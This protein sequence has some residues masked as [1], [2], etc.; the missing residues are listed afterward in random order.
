MHSVR[1]DPH[2]L[3]CLRYKSYPPRIKKKREKHPR[4]PDRLYVKEDSHRLEH[5]TPSLITC[6]DARQPT[7]GTKVRVH[8]G[9]KAS[10]QTPV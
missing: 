4:E 6:Q 1:L 9:A 3:A 5:D 8:E 10:A 7:E 2:T